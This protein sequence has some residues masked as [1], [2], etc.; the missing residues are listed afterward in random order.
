MDVPLAVLVALCGVERSPCCCEVRGAGLLSALVVA[1]VRRCCCP[2]QV[3]LLLPDLVG[4]EPWLHLELPSLPG[5]TI[6][7]LLGERCGGC[8]EDGGVKKSSY[9]CAGAVKVC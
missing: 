5:W 8:S 7:G 4:G 3:L 2:G 1:T 9:G 6:T